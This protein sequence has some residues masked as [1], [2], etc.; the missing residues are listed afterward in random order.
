MHLRKVFTLIFLTVFCL[1]ATA[2]TIGGRVVNNKNITLEGVSVTLR[3]NDDRPVAFCNTNEDGT[4]SIELP[5][6]ETPERLVFSMIGYAK[7]SIALND[8]KQGQ[9]VVLEN[10][11][12]MLKEVKVKAEKIRRSGDTLTYSVAAFMQKQDRSIADVIAKMPGLSVSPSGQIKYQGKAINKFYIEGAD[13]LGGKYALASENIKANQVKNVQ[14]L[15]DHQPV[16]ALKK[17]KFSDQAAL[18][19]V[20]KDDAKNVWQSVIEVGIGSSLQEKA[21]LLRDARLTEMLFSRKKQSISMY[22]TNNT[23][24]D[25]GH[26]TIDYTT[27]K[28]SLSADNPLIESVTISTPSISDERYNFNDTHIFATNWLVKTAKDNDL[29][30][31]FNG[32]IDKNKLTGHTH[33]TYLD[34]GTGGIS[35]TEDEAL[36]DKTNEWTAELTYKVN[37]DNHYFANVAKGYIGFN[38]SRGEAVLNHAP[39]LQ[40]VNKDKKVLS[41]NFEWIKTL[42]NNNTFSIKSRLLYNELPSS[43]LLVNGSTE[44]ISQQK[45]EWDATT[46]FR[47]KLLGMYITYNIGAAYKQQK[48][49]Q[50]N[51][52]TSFNATYTQAQVYILPSFSYITPSLRFNA[53]VSG[54]LLYRKSGSESKPTFHLEPFVF[55]NYRLTSRWNVNMLFSHALSPNAFS[56][57]IES[58][59]F[60]NYY[61]L[62]QGKAH[63]NNTTTNM[64]S[65]TWKYN[66]VI[67]GMFG[68]LGLSY[69]R[70]SNI[71]LYESVFED[72]FYKSRATDHTSCNSTT[73]ISGGIGKSIGWGKASIEFN[74]S[75][76]DN[77]YQLL[78]AKEV[79]DFTRRELSTGITIAY[80][81]WNVFS[82]EHKSSYNTSERKGKNY[83]PFNNRQTF[84]HHRLK[85]YLLPGKWQIEVSNELFQSQDKSISNSFF[86]DLSVSCRQKRWEATFIYNNILGTTSLEQTYNANA[87]QIYLQTRLRPSELLFKLSFSL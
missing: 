51:F 26:E 50:D 5:N 38:R 67:R 19:I 35:V 30:F 14:V 42:A 2:Q 10:D 64:L 44:R 32:L 18:N 21:Q 4:F 39:I 82:I 22:K 47:H 36:N 75:A 80:H 86:T 13:L 69:S 52:Y 43:L 46:G 8:F 7:R 58:P 62:M 33:K 83:A 77:N 81:P 57:Y 29:R 37:K 12:F 25:I 24:K 85:L 45:I 11:A 74:A 41:N 34:A 17:V 28:A 84:L 49:A 48:I 16:K 59:I 79:V 63:L 70:T 1:N 87:Q 72:G 9:D 73:S 31:Q 68:N 66:D 71:M 53:G 23:G 27:A 56:S 61:S 60:T 20:L 65:N 3:T 54:E 55:A 15:E 78:I 76:S 6:A 40:R